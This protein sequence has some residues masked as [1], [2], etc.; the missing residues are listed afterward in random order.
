MGHPTHARPPRYR[1][2]RRR[3]PLVAVGVVVLVLA[4]AAAWL[5]WEA[6]GVRD[7]LVAAAEQVAVL[8][9]RTL[10]DDAQ[11]GDASPG[12]DLR[13]PG[14]GAAPPD[15]APAADVSPAA[16]V[17]PATAD[18]QPADASTTATLDDLQ[19]LASHAR[20]VS[21][22]PLWRAASA[23]PWV[24]D[25]VTAVRVVAEVVDDL[26]RDALPPLLGA[27]GTVTPATLAPR[28]GRVDVAPLVRVAP[29]VLAADDAVRSAADRLA[30]LDTTRL[31]G[32]VAGPVAQ[33]RGTVDSVAAPVATAA[34]A[35][36]LLPPMLGG[37]GPR[38]YLVLVQNNAEPRATGGIPGSVLLL[39]AD[40]GRVE[41]LDDLRGGD[42][43]APEPALPLDEAEQ[44]LFGPLLASD[45]RDVT[46]TPDFVRTGELAAALWQRLGHEPVDGVLSVDPVALSLL[47]AA[48]GPVALPDGT[49]LGADDAVPLLL[50]EVYRRF[51][52]PADQ[53][54]FFSATATS[55]FAALVGGQGQPAAV[56]DALAEAARQ[57]RLMVWSAHD[58]EQA[59]LAGTVLSGALRRADDAP[60]IGV[61]LNDGTEAKLGY[62]LDLDVTGTAVEC[63]ADGRQ[64]VDLTLSVAS[65]VPVDLGG[66]PDYVTGGGK[67][68]PRG[69]TRTNILLYA[70]RDGWVQHFRVNSQDSVFTQ[71]NDGVFS[72]IHE[73]L[74]VAAMTVDLEPG[75]SGT[76]TAQIVTGQ[77]SGDVL[78]RST[79]TAHAPGSWTIAS[80][81]QGK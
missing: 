67:V 23:L 15:D 51:P 70:P 53:D 38:T 63:R 28:D 35:V 59:R 78:G 4:V 43:V 11:P 72:H 27:V 14:D 64:V 18:L 7:D 1:R 31:V 12:D 2:R 36:A 19:A 49:T 16:D 52:D 20:R 50:D 61:Y 33:L 47:L 13:P 8:R 32:A 40:D 10:A 22:G 48:T 81:C 41:V 46:F 45:M 77:W 73:D 80:A 76:L 6:R 62:Y 75:Q 56:V 66:L 44:A 69:V 26:A 54:A 25:Q 34:R 21:S 68:V 29:Q 9:D 42:L 79:P 37:D 57:G 60:V 39:R 17:P 24:G 30:A 65:R 55:A 5:A 71:I 58:D 74:P 3:W